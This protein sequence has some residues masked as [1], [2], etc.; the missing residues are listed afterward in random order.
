MDGVGVHSR[1]NSHS[2]LIRGLFCSLLA[3]H[4][5]SRQCMH[6]EYRTSRIAHQQQPSTNVYKCV[7][8]DRI[9]HAAVRP[10]SIQPPGP[11]SLRKL[12]YGN[13]VD[14]FLP[15][16]RIGASAI[17]SSVQ[18]TDELHASS[19]SRSCAPT[20]TGLHSRLFRFFIGANATL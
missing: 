16:Y 5:Y 7:N 19:L 18:Y 2:A 1:C 4:H 15:T 10:T 17:T 13:M 11:I 3:G 14:S 12:Q 6:T 9:N 8:V 20:T